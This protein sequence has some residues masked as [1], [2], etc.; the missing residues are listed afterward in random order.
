VSKLFCDSVLDIVL[1][2][3]TYDV[4]FVSD[5]TRLKGFL[6]HGLDS[7]LLVC[8]VD[9]NLDQE[10]ADF[11][12]GLTGSDLC[13]G[14]SFLVAVIISN[15]FTVSNEFGFCSTT[16]LSFEVSTGVFLCS[17]LILEDPK[18]LKIKHS[19]GNAYMLNFCKEFEL[20]FLIKKRRQFW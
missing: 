3:C 8:F 4:I 17:V 12:E 11:G 7:T 1:A 13:L 10:N 5:T 20:I 15:L 19:Y 14:N 6:E 2:D 16:E 18:Y 9:S